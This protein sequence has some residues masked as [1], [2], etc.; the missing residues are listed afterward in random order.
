MSEQEFDVRRALRAVCQRPWTVAAFVAVGALVPVGALAW[1]PPMDQATALVLVPGAAAST[2]SGSAVSNTNVTDSEIANSSVVLGPAGTKADPPLS[3]ETA[4]QRVSAVPVGTNL[5]QI[6]ASGPSPRQAEA[7]AD[8]VA[9]RLVNFTISSS[10]SL[11]GSA[12]TGLQAEAAQLTDQITSLD[13][14]IQTE[15][16]DLAATGSSSTAGQQATELLATL[17]TAASDAG[18]QLESVDSQIA[19]AKLDI[20][21][22]NGGT[23]VIQYATSASPPSL[24]RQ[25]LAVVAGALVGLVLGAG[26]VLIRHRRGLLVTRDEIAH[27]AGAPVLLSTTVGRWHRSS[28]WTATL[29]RYEP[30]AAERWNVTKALTGL[31]IPDAGQL[32]LTVITVAGDR[33]SMGLLTQFALSAAAMGI[34]TSIAITS[35]DD[36]SVALR[37]AGDLLAAR[38]ETARPN[39]TLGKGLPPADE[40]TDLTLVS[41]VVDPVQPKLPAYVARGVILLAVPSGA[42]DEEQV[43]RVLIAV[44]REGLSLTGVFVA[45]PAAEDQTAGARVG[46]DDRVREIVRRHPLDGYPEPRVQAWPGR[47]VGVDGG[48]S[49]PGEPY[50][51]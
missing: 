16:N 20:A 19:A 41:I 42:V 24:L 35:D 30:T 18:L 29:R 31:E 28:D 22:T 8:A 15:R 12:L 49:L 21:A 44:G 1:H 40:S 3:L 7:L 47:G 26:Y 33:A 10:S 32:V 27:A 51:G 34:P 36:A 38:G 9:T 5:V 14:Q 43:A 50:D 4:K 46:P 37:N 11:Q 45:N 23:E 25:V 17:T 48:P 6:T 13:K 39:L 2:S